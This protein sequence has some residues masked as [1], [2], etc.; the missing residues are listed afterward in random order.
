MTASKYKLTEEH[1]ARFPEWRDKW[2]ANAMSTK[3]MGPEEK[4]TIR[5]AI[6]GLYRAADLEPPP[7]HRIVFV[8]NPIMG[9]FA[10]G[11][12]AWRWHQAAAT[13]A[14]TVAATRDATV[15]ATDKWHA[16]GF[17]IDHHNSAERACA[18][19]FYFMRNGGNQWSGYVAY[20]SFFR[21]VA[22]LNL[23]YS[24]WKHYETAA[25]AGPRYMHKKF[26]IVSERPTT[27][28]VDDEN[29]PHC[30]DGPF[31]EWSDGTRL[32][33]VNGVY[34]P[35]W[36]VTHPERLTVKSIR[37]ENNAEIRRIMRER[38]G[39][40]RYLADIGSKVL[41]VDT[42]PVDAL[43]PGGKSIHRALIEDDDDQRWLVGSDGSTRRVYHMR[44]PDGT[45]TCIE[46]Y[47]A[48]RWGRTNQTIME[49]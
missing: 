33:A 31:C 40:G 18:R 10:A 11:A 4:E 23:D 16:L 25:T 28:L 8:A 14:A 12:A 29:R 9:A 2:I 13:D 43:A 3:P 35:G 19:Q 17:G 30:D 49:A 1:R 48:L 39:E 20:L 45:G 22:K 15:D 27:L 21:H 24:K 42:V 26:C 47:D 36:I 7:R 38:Y 6:V 32:F 37:A 5:N 46:A 44:V 41:D 34:V